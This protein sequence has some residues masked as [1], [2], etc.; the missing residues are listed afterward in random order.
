M[1]SHSR[2]FPFSDNMMGKRY[3]YIS[4]AERKIKKEKR[5]D[6]NE[7]KLTKEEFVMKWM[8]EQIEDENDEGNE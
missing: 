3:E 2:K 4:W 6:D 7:R 5:K 1:S 8:R